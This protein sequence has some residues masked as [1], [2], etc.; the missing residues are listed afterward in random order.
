MAIIVRTI[1]RI[2]ITTPRNNVYVIDGKCFLGSIKKITFRN[3]VAE[4]DVILSITCKLGKKI[5]SN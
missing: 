1:N 2:A 5:E 4:S 3:F